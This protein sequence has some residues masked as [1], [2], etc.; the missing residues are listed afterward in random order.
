MNCII[1]DD[2]Y[3]SREILTRLVERVKGLDLVGS[4]ESARSA[5]SLLHDKKVDLI[6]LDVEMPELS[7]IDFLDMLDDEKPMIIFVTS[8]EEYAVKAFDFEAVD[9]LL[10]PVQKD[11]FNRAVEKAIDLFESKQSVQSGMTHLFV[12][13]DGNLVR[14]RLSSILYV[15]AAADYMIIFTES[16]R[17]IVHTTMKGL[18]ERLPEDEFARIH[19]TYTVRLDKV[20]AI[21]DQAVVVAGK[22][23]AIGGTYKKDFLQ[24]LER[25]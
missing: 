1:V 16:E 21:E 13:K 20:E 10:K 6:F 22:S 15:E 8:K 9:Y 23:L 14:I 18:I 19:R 17:F 2:E 7:G 11:R 24:Q 12:K 4:C 3:I 5:K 25:L